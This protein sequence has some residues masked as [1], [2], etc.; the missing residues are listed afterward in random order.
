MF[1]VVMVFRIF[2]IEMEL[3]YI[4]YL[5]VPRLEYLLSLDM[6]DVFCNFYSALPRKYWGSRYISIDHSCV[7]AGPSIIIIIITLR[8]V[9]YLLEKVILEASGY[10]PFWWLP[11]HLRV[12]ERL[13]GTNHLI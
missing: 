8:R 3:V 9:T 10:Q 4:V 1:F 13:A 5:G 11:A 7:H 6:N 12:L 2:T